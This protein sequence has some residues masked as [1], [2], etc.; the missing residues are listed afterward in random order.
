M[1]TASNSRVYGEG[2]ERVPAKVPVAEMR[3]NNY[4]EGEQKN[5]NYRRRFGRGCKCYYSR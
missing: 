3:Q 1:L 2:E 5:V 4:L